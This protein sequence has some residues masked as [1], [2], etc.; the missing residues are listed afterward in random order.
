M[1]PN[2]VQKAHDYATAAKAE[3]V[4]KKRT[5]RDLH[6]RKTGWAKSLEIRFRQDKQAGEIKAALWG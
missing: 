3:A 5:A 1:N 4:R 6:A 2:Q